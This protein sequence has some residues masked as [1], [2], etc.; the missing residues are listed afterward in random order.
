MAILFFCLHLLTGLTIPL[1]PLLTGLFP[2]LGLTPLKLGHHAGV[3]LGQMVI[4]WVFA[5]LAVWASDFGWGWAAVLSGLWFSFIAVNFYSE[6]VFVALEQPLRAREGLAQAAPV[7]AATVGGEVVAYPL[8]M[9]VPHHL[10]NDLL[11]E[12]P[13]LVSW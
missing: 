9:L 12:I 4:V 3:R 1:L 8:E 6:R 11:G 2:R 5:L 13:V 10:I 7:I